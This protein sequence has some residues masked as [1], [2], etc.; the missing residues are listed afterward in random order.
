MMSCAAGH[1]V[2][3]MNRA[4]SDSLVHQIPLLPLM[5]I[6][7]ADDLQIHMQMILTIVRKMGNVFP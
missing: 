4:Q 7:I 3:G 5:E 2:I 6:Q 1:H